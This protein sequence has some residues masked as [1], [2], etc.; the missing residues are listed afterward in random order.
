[1]QHLL[2]H[3]VQDVQNTCRQLGLQA[4]VQVILHVC[5]NVDV[6]A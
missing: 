4:V 1:M 5:G 3:V 2:F 6:V